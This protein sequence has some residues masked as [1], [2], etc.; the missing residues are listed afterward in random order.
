[1]SEQDEKDEE[2][3]EDEELETI[4]IKLFTSEN[5]NLRELCSHANMDPSS[6]IACVLDSQA[7]RLSAWKSATI[8]VFYNDNPRPA[9]EGQWYFTKQQFCGLV[10]TLSKCTLSCKVIWLLL[11]KRGWKMKTVLAH[12]ED[13]S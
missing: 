2:D 7:K 10:Y 9:N 5:N 8:E 11:Q 1:M 6:Y 4:E 12:P 3:E 13:L